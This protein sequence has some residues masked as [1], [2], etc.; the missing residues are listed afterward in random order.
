MY[1]SKFKA[2]R[3]RKVLEKNSREKH[4]FELHYCAREQQ[5]APFKMASGK[6]KK[7]S[8]S[9]SSKSA[10]HSAGGKGEK[11]SNNNEVNASET[12]GAIQLPRKEGDLFNDALISYEHRK[13][14]DALH[15]I[16]KILKKFPNHGET[17]CMKGLI[18]R[19]CELKPNEQEEERKK[20][21]HEVVS[22]GVK[23]NIF[24]HVC[25]NV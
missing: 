18:T 3:G 20:K 8:S 15:A 4:F 2:F 6:K 11:K 13:F 12:N 10:T 5:R 23:N 7:A 1:Q 21:A 25:W 19:H 22:Q 17:L 9:S 14:K 16:E 24:A